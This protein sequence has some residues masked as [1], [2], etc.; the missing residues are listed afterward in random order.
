MSNNYPSNPS[1]RTLSPTLLLWALFLIGI[2]F[3]L[4]PAGFPQPAYFLLPLLVLSI[5]IKRGMSG[6]RYCYSGQVGLLL[7]LGLFVIYTLL[8]ALA[9]FL[10]LGDVRLLSYPIYYIFNAI[11]FWTALSLRQ[12]HGDRFEVLTA[13]AL[14]LSISL[15]LLLLIILGVR[16]QIRQSLY[17]NNPNQLGYYALLTASVLLIMR[18]RIKLSIP[19]TVW[20]V[21]TAFILCIASLSRSAL[22]ALVF[23]LFLAFRKRPKFMVA[24][25][26]AIFVALLVAWTNLPPLARERL[27]MRTMEIDDSLAGR[28]YDR[29]INHPEYLLFGA[30]E[31]AFNRFDSFLDGEIHSSLGTLIFAYGVPGSILFS[32]FLAN[33]LSRSGG[34][35][36]LLLI[37]ALSYGLTHQGL[38]FTMFW[39]LLSLTCLPSAV[40]KRHA[41]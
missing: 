36:W 25:A 2:P 23:L 16:G 26:F 11:L 19:W 14:V 22:A 9:W 28:G 27:F 3:Y 1:E 32:L 12:E 8:V 15:Q 41:T 40:D 38:R 13:R 20:G 39:I 30:G 34:Y 4:F 21:T 18:E 17:F 35:T 7:T 5:F 33:V 37:P 29:I 10:W 24:G 31:G 6:L